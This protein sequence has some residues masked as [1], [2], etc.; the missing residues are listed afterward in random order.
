[1]RDLL[2]PHIGRRVILITDDLSLAGT[3]ASV[4]RAGDAE[5]AD[6]RAYRDDPRQGP[7]VDANV[8]GIALVPAAAIRWVQVP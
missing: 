1:M 4:T 6:V 5:L 7:P 3:L 2:R 8:D